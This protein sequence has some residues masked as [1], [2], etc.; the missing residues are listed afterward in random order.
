MRVYPNAGL[1][2]RDPVKKDLLPEEG[3]EVRDTDLYW[4]RRIAHGD[5]VTQSITTQP[6]ISARTRS[7]DE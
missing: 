4:H 3:L 2:V 1:K 7:N 6:V 5:V